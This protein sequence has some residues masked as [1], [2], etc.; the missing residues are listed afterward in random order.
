MSK[1]KLFKSK[2]NFTLKRLHQ[3]GSYGNIY[4]RDYT[5][6]SNTGSSPEG[7]IPIYNTPSFKMSVRSGLNVQKKYNYGSWVGNPVGDEKDKWTLEAMPAPNVF[8]NKVVLKNNN[9]KLTDFVYYGSAFELI[10]ATISHVATYFPAELRVTSRTLNET[11]LLN[12]D[13]IPIDARIR[14]YGNYYLVDNPYKIDITQQV[15]PENSIVSP[16]RYLCQSS[17]KYLIIDEESVR[18]LGGW[19]V[20]SYETKECLSDGDRLGVVI[21]S[22]EIGSEM[23]QIECFYFNNDIIY[24]SPNK[25]YRLR[26]NNDT[27]DQFFNEL[28][29]FG[30]VLLNRD[31]NYTSCFETYVEN[32]ET[33][34][35]MRL[36]KYQW[37]VDEGKWNP[38][39]GGK[40]YTDYVNKLSD[41]ALTHDELF[42]DNIWRTMTHEAISNLDL[43]LQRNGE[44]LDVANSSK[45]RKTLNI[46]G[47]MFDDLKKS[48]SGI[49]NST[50]FSY[51][52]NANCPDYFLPD[53]LEN[54]GWE[55][56]NIFSTLSNDYI[57]ETTYGETPI[58]ASAMDANNEFMRRLKLNSQNILSSKGTKRGIED[59]MGVFGFHSTDWLRRYNGGRI[60]VNSEELRRAFIL[61]E[62]VYVVDGYSQNIKGSELIE[63]VQ[64]INQLKD[65]FP[66]EN[67]NNDEL[68]DVYYGLPV[69]EITNSIGESTLIPWFDKHNSYDGDI[70][71][72]MKGGWSRNDENGV[73]EKS[74][75]KIQYVQ[76]VDDL[77]GLDYNIIDINSLYY[78]GNESKYYKIKDLENH[79]TIDG[80]YTE[81]QISIDEISD[82]EKIVDNNKGNNPHTGDYDA[83]MSYLESFA[84]LF[85]NS[86]FSNARKDETEGQINKYGFNLMRQED[87]TKCIYLTNNG[88]VTKYDL[89]NK[90]LR[91]KNVVEPYNPFNGEKEYGEEAGTSIINNKIFHIVFDEAHKEFIIDAILPYLKQM[92]PSTAI[93]SYSFETL[94]GDDTIVTVAK[95]HKIICDGDSC[96]IYGIVS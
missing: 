48:A 57:S 60:P 44:P 9:T 18:P 55:A 89:Y 92:I 50:S 20:E 30:K 86:E 78:V 22:D 79:T 40:S 29:D 62:Y 72:Q 58:E 14:T 10:K 49:K 25:N 47:R 73:Y 43:T 31:T 2:T 7:Q 64:R 56:K 66:T 70:Y 83:G 33:G 77:L 59:L 6:I 3:S 61:Y 69:A 85:K 68:L 28:D 35:E 38:L 46:I 54:S 76:T 37:P 88:D 24:L 21:F 71:F 87:S 4:E 65:N 15:I 42:T 13:N 5:T 17:G 90:S 39:I 27:V 74:V 32:D 12:G 63:N 80:W 93:F 19:S 96:S 81:N 23:M 53:A 34:W 41:L 84:T 75:S 1:K 95:T 52:Q 26:P 67:I 8:D 94:T 16:L 11:G 82:A 91:K 51:D 45:L 36:E